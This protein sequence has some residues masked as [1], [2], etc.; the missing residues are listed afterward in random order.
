LSNPAAGAEVPG[1][2]A[3]DWGA[4]AE[5]TAVKEGYQ[6][7]M[8]AAGLE[9]VSD[10]VGAKVAVWDWVVVAKGKAA[11]ASGLVVAEKE[12]AA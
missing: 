6:E 9:E 3:R 11:E 7:A 10:W 2:E 4:V 1:D 5:E 12:A 8:A